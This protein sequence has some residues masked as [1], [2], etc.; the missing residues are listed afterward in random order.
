MPLPGSFEGSPAGVLAGWSLTALGLALAGPG[1]THL[2]G[3]L[4]QSARPGAIRLLAGRT[5]M[6]EARRI[7]RPLGVLCAVVSGMF[8]ATALYGPGDERP[9]AR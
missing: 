3:L 5:L 9:S 6:T 4:L 7:G 2:C 1:M 8:A